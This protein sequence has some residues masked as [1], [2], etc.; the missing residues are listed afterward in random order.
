MHYHLVTLFPEWFSSPLNTALFAKANQ[1]G[2]VHVD[3]INPRDFTKN[4]HHK[5]DDSPY[6]GGPGMVLMAQPLFH[7]LASIPQ[8]GRIIALTP[9]GKPLT[10][11]LAE[12]LAKEEHLTLICGRYEGF[13]ERLY[14]LLPIERISVGDAI[15]NGGEVAALALIEATAR[16]QDGY[17]GKNESG[18]EESFTQN[19]LEYPHYTRPETYMDLEVPTVLQHGNHSEINAW[20]REQALAMTLKYRPDL[21]AKAE[22]SEQDRI[23]LN[24]LRTRSFAKNIH[25][26]LVHHP[27]LLK[28]NMAG[29]SSVTNLDL[30]DIARIACTYGLSSLQIIT[31]ITDQKLLVQELLEHWT[32]G[33]G[34]KTN[35]DRA[36]ALSL[37]QLADNIEEATAHVEKISGTKPLLIGTSAKAE[38]D[39]KGREKRLA[40]PF[41]KITELARENSLLLVFGTSHGLAPEALA[42]CDYILPPLRYMGQY[43]HLPVRSACAIIVD[44]LLGDIY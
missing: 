10:Q 18:T 27:V 15:L 43:N 9:A 32:K 12:E 19:L 33:E 7:A 31:P 22:L 11:K 39:K 5:V 44:R 30:H 14:D 4:K 26:A 38:K 36:K 41:C 25:I 2:I 29:S 21:L 17:M 42:K 6:G 35:P 23:T 37:A 40:A 20:R 16:L 34:A 13:D 24:T 8:K 1:A 3:Y 28:N